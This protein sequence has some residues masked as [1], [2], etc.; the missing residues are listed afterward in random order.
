MPRTL[1]ITVVHRGGRRPTI[2]A[3]DNGS[4]MHVIGQTSLQNSDLLQITSSSN[5][6]LVDDG[7]G[8]FTLTLS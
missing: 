5:V 3:L 2:Q 1:S 4:S 6:T 7:S 8:N